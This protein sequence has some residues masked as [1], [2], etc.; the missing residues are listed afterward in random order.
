MVQIKT[1]QAPNLQKALALVRS[2]FGPD[3]SI[4]ETRPLSAT[5]R[6]WLSAN[7]VE[8]VASSV[9]AVGSDFV[10]HDVIVDEPRSELASDT[11]MN[12][13]DVLD[14]ERSATDAVEDAAPSEGVPQDG[15]PNDHAFVPVI[16]TEMNAG[17]DQN[18]SGFSSPPSRLPPGNSLLDEMH[19]ELT[20]TGIDSDIADDWCQ[21]LHP[22]WDEQE[23]K[24]GLRHQLVSHIQ[25]RLPPV[26]AI[27]LRSD[28]AATRIALIGS[29]GS[30]KTTTIAKLAA[31]LCNESGLSLGL[32]SIDTFHYGGSN[33]LSHYA[34][35]L[36]LPF[37]EI[38]R[39]D[40]I[41]IGLEQLADCSLIL[42]D[43]MG[44]NTNELDDC[45]ELAHIL[46][47][48]SA[49]ETHLLLPASASRRVLKA[50]QARLA[51]CRPTHRLITKQDEAVDF[52][53]LFPV[54]DTRSDLPAL[55]ISYVTHGRRVP[56][57]IRTA[58]KTTLA[59]RM[60]S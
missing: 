12:R 1:F 15:L 39:V 19:R 16:G 43:T 42:V 29:A 6:N 26:E 4:L 56:A 45:E 23:S 34:D 24:S 49:D 7:R 11:T 10:R 58:N 41:A 14:S 30:G 20:A 38:D 59:L 52:G 28:G 51:D 47:V 22:K 2:E 46:T 60:L 18:R 25:S 44:V 36:S 50:Q 3:A 5:I 17:I 9:A 57:D 53:N 13:A 48:L 55:P 21:T 54:L 32:A 8:V 27:G 31:S 37:V 35:M 40:D 33:M